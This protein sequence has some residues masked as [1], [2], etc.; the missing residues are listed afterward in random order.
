[1]AFHKPRFRLVHLSLLIAVIAVELAV[2]PTSFSWAFALFD[3][4]PGRTRLDIGG[5]KDGVGGHHR[6]PGPTDRVAGS[7]RARQ[8]APTPEG[9]SLHDKPACIR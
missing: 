6:N 8:P 1:M 9:Q 2:L 5:H 3:L 7:G 4:P